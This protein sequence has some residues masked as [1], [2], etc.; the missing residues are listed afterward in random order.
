MPASGD[1]YELTLKGPAG[2][3]LVY[4]VFMTSPIRFAETNFVKSA[5]TVV[6]E[7]AEQFTRD[8]NVALK[9]IPLKE[10]A[11]AAL[12]INVTQ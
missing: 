10:Q 1:P 3:E 7:S 5:F 9:T 8:I 4:V 6:N 11:N 12:E 2:V